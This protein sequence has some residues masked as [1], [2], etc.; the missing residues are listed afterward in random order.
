MTVISFENKTGHNN[1]NCN[2]SNKYNY[3]LKAKSLCLLKCILWFE[4]L[5]LY[6]ESDDAFKFL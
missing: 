2:D 5:Q 1:N 3:T 4:S 6:R